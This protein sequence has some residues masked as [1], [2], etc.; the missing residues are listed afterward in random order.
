MMFEAEMSQTTIL[1]RETKS[2]TGKSLSAGLRRDFLYRHEA[3]LTTELSDTNGSSE[4]EERL[5]YQPPPEPIP[6]LTRE[7]FTAHQKWECYVLAVRADTFLARLHPIVGEG[8]IRRP[9]ST[10]KKCRRRI[11][12]WSKK[13]PF[14]IGVSAI[15]S[16]HRGGSGVL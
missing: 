8:A 6:F 9:K 12:P 1:T 3:E 14:S 11:A 10:L 5:V 2:A 13:G 15:W 16:D 4:K 7:F